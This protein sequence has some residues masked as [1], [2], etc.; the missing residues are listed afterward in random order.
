MTCWKPRED[1]FYPYWWS[2]SSRPGQD[3][4]LLVRSLTPLL[5]QA[6]STGKKTAKGKGKIGNAP[7]FCRG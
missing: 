7:H 2:C 1:I 5:T 4:V 3:V 6:V